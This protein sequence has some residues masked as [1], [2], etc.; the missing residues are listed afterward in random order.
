MKDDKNDIRLWKHQVLFGN[1]Q[2][3]H[4]KMGLLRALEDQKRFCLG[5]E[6]NARMYQANIEALEKSNAFMEKKLFDKQEEILKIQKATQMIRF[7]MHQSEQSIAKTQ[8]ML[9]AVRQIHPGMYKENPLLSKDLKE[10]LAI[11]GTTRQELV[12]KIQQD[13]QEIEIQEAAPAKLRLLRDDQLLLHRVKWVLSR[14]ELETVP[15]S[16]SALSTD[17][18]EKETDGISSSTSTSNLR[19]ERQKKA[20]NRELHQLVALFQ[21]MRSGETKALRT[22]NNPHLNEKKQQLQQT[23]QQQQSPQHQEQR[24]SWKLLVMVMVLKKKKKKKKKKILL[25]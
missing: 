18:K 4:T 17:Q 10:V 25:R 23:S 8:G 3:L 22:E 19:Q 5:L 12:T 1:V 9:E 21:F 16:S 6:Q 7:G 14:L 13:E 24:R 15:S 2:E 20:T 11:H